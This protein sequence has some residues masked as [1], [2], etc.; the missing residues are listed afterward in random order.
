MFLICHLDDSGI[1]AVCLGGVC[2]YVCLNPHFK[3]V[4]CVLLRSYSL[5]EFACLLLFSLQ[6]CSEVNQ[7]TVTSPE[8][9]EEKLVSR[10]QNVELCM[11][12]YIYTV[13]IYT[14]MFVFIPSSSSSLYIWDQDPGSKHIRNWKTEFFIDIQST[15]WSKKSKKMDA[16][17]SM[18]EMYC[19]SD[20]YF[21]SQR[22]GN[23]N[24]IH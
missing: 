5:T 11:L 7:T 19:L 2:M 6:C 22:L 20:S 9:G 14:S 4:Q 15:R 12:I 21:F 13:Y 1:L 24:V 16:I 3:T 23:N 18:A 17:S 10:A 8:T